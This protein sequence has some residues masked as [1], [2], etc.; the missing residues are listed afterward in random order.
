MEPITFIL[1]PAAG[2]GKAE[3]VWA[4]AMECLERVGQPY[5]LVRT[6]GRGE[7][8]VMASRATTSKVVA[9][10]GDGTIQ[11]VANGIIGTEKTM[12][13]VPAGSGNDLIK[14]LGIGRSIDAAVDIILAAE[15]RSIDVGGV[16]CSAEQDDDVSTNHQVGRYFVNGVGVGF[17]A[18]VA[19]RTQEIPWLTGPLLYLAAVFQTLGKY[20]APEFRVRMD[21][22]AFDSQNLLFAVGN[23]RCAGGGF[24]LTPEAL[25][26]DGLLDV[27]SIRAASVRRILTLM[28]KAMS[29]NHGQAHEVNFFR[30]RS[31]HLSSPTPF[32]VHADG[33]VVGR[34]VRSVAVS[35]VPKVLRVLVPGGGIGA[36]SQRTGAPQ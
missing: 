17:D 10:G 9:V 21:G 25:V 3:R 22:Q 36:G 35:I 5:V 16:R 1:N 33:E 7:A 14:S 6:S 28:P 19:A 18:A 2:K 20:Q 29:G 31:L 27:C 24:Y 32:Y 4:R 13:I 11:E 30:T 23:G 34:S 26:D 8:S 15:E 12:G